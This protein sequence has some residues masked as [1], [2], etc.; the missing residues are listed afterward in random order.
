MKKNRIDWASPSN[1]AIVKYWGKYGIQLPMNPSLSFTLS[2]CKTET[3]V[4]WNVVKDQKNCSIE[5]LYDGKPKPAFESKIMKFIASIENSIPCLQNLHLK[6]NSRN[7]FPHSAG[8]ASSASAMSAL[9]LCLVSIE[10]EINQVSMSDELFFTRASQFARLGSG[11]AARSLYPK[12][13]IWGEFN[14]QKEFSNEFAI[15]FGD[16]LHPM[17]QNI[18]DCIIIVN[19]AE[20]MV[21]ST[22]GHQLMVNHPYRQ[23]RIEQALRNMSILIDA[24]QTGDWQQ[25]AL[26]CEEEALSLHGL[27]MSS[28]PGYILLEPESLHVISEI[29]KFAKESKLPV[30]FTID[31]GPNIH[32]LYPKEIKSEVEQWLQIQIPDYWKSNKF[33]FDCMG[34]GPAQLS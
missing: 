22:A 31:A 18:Q 25:F 28:T 12:A 24:L 32:L 17:F 26:V 6:I 8:I 4:E 19:Q 13:A 10:Q 34:S 21:S 1:I 14:A 11:S 23:A 20:K 9:A 16:K 33:I 27:M 30:T 3:N 15:P 29:K 5:F 2:E 7:T